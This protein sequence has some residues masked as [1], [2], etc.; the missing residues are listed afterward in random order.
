MTSLATVVTAYAAG[1]ICLAG[2]AHQAGWLHSAAAAVKAGRRRRPGRHRAVGLSTAQRAGTSASYVEAHRPL[3]ALTSVLEFPDLTGDVAPLC[4]PMYPP[5]V[6]GYAHRLGAGRY[7]HLGPE[8]L[9]TTND[10]LLRLRGIGQ[11]P[12]VDLAALRVRDSVPTVGAVDD[13]WLEVAA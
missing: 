12:A 2:V 5:L 9:D 6:E 1:V 10:R 3:P 7:A 4:P 8:E 11:R 13:E